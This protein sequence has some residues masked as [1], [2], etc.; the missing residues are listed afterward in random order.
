MS[1]V[2]EIGAPPEA[3]AGNAVPPGGKLG[4][5]EFLK[6]LITQLRYQDPLNPIDSQE[7]I[8]QLA[9]FSA[10]EQ[11]QNLNVQFEGF[12]REGNLIQSLLLNGE[13]IVAE[14]TDGSVV[15]GIV[16]KVTQDS[17]GMTLQING[18]SYPVVDIVSMAKIETP[19]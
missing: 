12:R 19:A 8:A 7:T 2:G 1:E 6:L 16:E 11:M 14:L 15:E 5:D 18:E 13:T 4:K 10:L 3:V 9:Q 17:S